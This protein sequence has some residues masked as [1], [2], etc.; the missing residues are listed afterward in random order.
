MYVWNQKIMTHLTILNLDE[1]TSIDDTEIYDFL[2]ILI[3]Q[4]I[5]LSKF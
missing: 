5:Q 2:N 4:K 3:L 1:Y